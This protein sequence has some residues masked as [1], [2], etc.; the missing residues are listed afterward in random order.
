VNDTGSNLGAGQ[1]RSGI[2]PADESSKE[3]CIEGRA[4][5]MGENQQRDADREQNRP[6]EEC[7]PHAEQD[8]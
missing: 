4:S 2:Q 7:E 1:R 6:K 5:E 8:A 3:G